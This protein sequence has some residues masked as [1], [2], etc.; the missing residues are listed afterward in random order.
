[1]GVGFLDDTW[2]YLFVWAMSLDMF[3]VTDTG[4]AYESFNYLF[5]LKN[6]AVHYF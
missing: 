2:V 5:I 4:W 1:M 3:D 6:F